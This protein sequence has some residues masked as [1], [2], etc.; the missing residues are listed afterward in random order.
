[1]A[2]ATVPFAFVTTS[3]SEVLLAVTLFARGLGL[4]LTMMPVTA[5]AYY[6]LKHSEIPKASTVM[7]IVRLIG[8]SVATAFFAVILERQIESNL[9]SA[10]VKVPGGTG[11]HRRHH[12]QAPALGR[13]PGGRGVRPHVLVVGGRD[14]DRLR[15][16]AV[17]AESHA[18]AGAGPRARTRRCV[19]VA[20]RRRPGER[21]RG[22][23][24]ERAPRCRGDDRLTAR[25]ERQLMTMLTDMLARAG[26]VAADE[27]AAE[28][29]AAAGGNRPKLIGLVHR[30]IRGEP[31]A[32]V[33]GTAIFGD[34]TITVEPG[35]Y[36]PRWQSLEPRPRAAARLPE[37][38]HAIDLC[39]GSGAI[40][41]TLGALRPAAHVV[42]TDCDPGAIACARANGV[43]A[44]RGDLFDPVPVE[45]EGATDVVVAVV[46]YVP[47][48][49]LH[50]LPHDVRT[51][52]AATHYHGGLDGTDVL[53]RVIEG[54]PKFL[55][56]GGALFSSW[57]VR[58]P[59]WC[60][61][62]WRAWATRG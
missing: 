57:A 34:L 22:R 39:T 30:R 15:P 10:G 51:F 31:L 25:Q 55:R 48:P 14:P 50:L 19:W 21:R 8:G 49:A 35:I 59:R 53:R 12:G 37:S 2:A 6:D 26:C 3:T 47:T 42:G 33:T 52:E 44:L 13:R 60:R 45:F 24:H 40:A 27:E 28:L 29:V 4:G 1:M 62:S 58:R 41:A 54:A 56:P 61:R 46:P 36:V 18:G 9:A 43:E 38:G 5:A 17:P 23:P 16:D 11:R 32:W 20:H 7:N